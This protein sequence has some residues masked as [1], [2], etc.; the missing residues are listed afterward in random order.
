MKNYEIGIRLYHKQNLPFAVYSKPNSNKVVA[1]LQRN[2]RIVYA[3]K[4]REGFVFTPFI[5]GRKMLISAKNAEIFVEEF[6]NEED[7]TSD[8]S[9][10]S[11]VDSND[12]ADFEAMVSKAVNAIKNNDF[13]KV[14]LS[15]KEVIDIRN[16][17]PYDIFQKLKA[18][19]PDAFCY[20]FFHPKVGMWAGATPERLIKKENDLIETVSLAG[21]ALHVDNKIVKWNEKEI[22]EQKIV[23]DYIQNSL[24]KYVSRIS[25]SEPY[26]QKAG[27]L[28][29][30]KTDIKAQLISSSDFNKV[31]RKLHPTPAVCGFPKKEALQFIENNEGYSREFYTGYAGEWFKNLETGVLDSTELY[32]NLRCM[33]IEDHSAHVFV[34]CGITKDSIPEDEYIETVN[35]SQTMKK[36]LNH[37]I[38][39]SKMQIV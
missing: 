5:G 1:I 2:K 39:K 17:S 30:L 31:I 35:K 23:T 6:E 3:S 25:I 8:F 28:V 34:G 21:T 36:V 16:H 32:V 15:R 11:N 37:Y 38:I 4:E 12:K 10:Y 29:H 20:V 19:Y 9:S 24:K 13:Q 27:S 22:L 26:S 18:T 7:C 14:V 33:K